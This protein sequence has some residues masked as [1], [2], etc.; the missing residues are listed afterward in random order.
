MT[1]CGAIQ[2]N[3]LLHCESGLLHCREGVQCDAGWRV[4][5]AFERGGAVYNEAHYASSSFSFDTLQCRPMQCS[6]LQFIMR[7]ITPPPPSFQCKAMPCNAMHFAK[8]QQRFT[9]SST[10]RSF[11][12]CTTQTGAP[13]YFPKH[14]NQTVHCSS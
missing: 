13:T 9:P 1:H 12:P 8:I 4:V 7:H 5:S 10:K 2:A 6:R 11:S 3:S 14:Y